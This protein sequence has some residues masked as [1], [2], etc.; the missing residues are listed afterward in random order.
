MNRKIVA[1]NQGF[2]VMEDE[3]FKI[4]AFGT[5]SALTLVLPRGGSF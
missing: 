3:I 1:N 5:I 4:L 2:K